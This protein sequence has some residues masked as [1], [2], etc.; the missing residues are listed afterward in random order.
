MAAG[1]H[2]KGFEDTLA[3]LKKLRTGLD[4]KA[5]DRAAK[6]ALKPIK[7]DA[8]STV[9]SNH[10][11]D[12]KL[13]KSIK[14]KQM[15]RRQRRRFGFASGAVVGADYRIAPHA[16]LIE[17]GTKGRVYKTGLGSYRYTGKVRGSKFLTKA[18]DRNVNTVFA[19]FRKSIIPEIERVKRK[20][21]RT[22]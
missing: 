15:N 16:H 13:F 20:A 17:F 6:E 22:A 14:V 2:T 8:K 5:I 10:N 7:T 11:K 9:K 21:R 18:K 3:A 19:R 12:G 4:K 1:R